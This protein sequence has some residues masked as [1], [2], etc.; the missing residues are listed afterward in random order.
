[1]VNQKSS[2]RSVI[3]F[4][5]VILLILQFTPVGNYVGAAIVILA[6][7][8]GLLGNPNEMPSDIDY[9][10][11][12]MIPHAKHLQIQ[13]IKEVVIGL[14]HHYTTVV[15]Y[16]PADNVDIQNL[17]NAVKCIYIDNNLAHIEGKDSLKIKTY[18]NGRGVGLTGDFNP[19]HA[20][21]ISPSMRSNDLSRIVQDIVKRKAK[22]KSP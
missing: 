21:V 19:S 10:R 5:I 18:I 16:K 17:T 7:M 2:L 6:D 9:A 8:A 15:L 1:M 3:L 14:D 4:I 13:D 20:P 12:I 22:E 11:N